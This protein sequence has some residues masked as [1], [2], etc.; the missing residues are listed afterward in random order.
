MPVEQRVT[1]ACGDSKLDKEGLKQEAMHLFS[2]VY[3][4][5]AVP[6]Q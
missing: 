4:N 1:G 6:V 3:A 2:K 5:C